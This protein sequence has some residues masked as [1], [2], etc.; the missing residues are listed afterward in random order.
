[1]LRT[2]RFKLCK[3]LFLVEKYSCKIIGLGWV[4]PRMV[5]F[6][7]GKVVFLAWCKISTMNTETAL[8]SH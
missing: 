2:V 5:R 7:P 8:F 4:V 6:K 3:A 1:M